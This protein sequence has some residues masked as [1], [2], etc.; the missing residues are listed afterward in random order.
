MYR[1]RQEGLVLDRVGVQTQVLEM[2]LDVVD[3]LQG[4]LGSGEVRA[5]SKG[6]EVGSHGVVGGKGEED[7]AKAESIS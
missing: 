5:Q 6:A 3:G 4:R 7:L 2:G 1:I